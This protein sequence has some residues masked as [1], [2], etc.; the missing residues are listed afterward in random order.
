MNN[1]KQKVLDVLRSKRNQG[2]THWDFHNGF[3]L[4]SRIADLR[5]LGHEIITQM[6]SNDGNSGKHARYFL[7]KMARQ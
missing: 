5:K 7:I 3:A 2:I 6:E 4:R 1:S